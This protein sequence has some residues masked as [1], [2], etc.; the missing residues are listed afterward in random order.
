MTLREVKEAL[1]AEVLCGHDQLDAEV[2]GGFGSDLV[3]DSLFFATPGTVLLTGLTHPQ[4]VRTA[5]LMEFAG[6]V[7]VRGKRPPQSVVELA[8]ERRIPVLLTRHLLFDSCGLL[9]AAGLRGCRSAQ[10]R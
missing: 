2:A 7:F 8:R 5:E 10:G 3:S 1:E 6:I 4:V 9:Y